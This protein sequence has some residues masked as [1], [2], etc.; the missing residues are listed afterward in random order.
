M[1][2][3]ITNAVLISIPS[4]AFPVRVIIET[5]KDSNSIPN[6]GILVIISAILLISDF[7]T[8]ILFHFFI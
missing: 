1:F 4:R 3:L 5:L 2:L 8:S 7:L 6:S